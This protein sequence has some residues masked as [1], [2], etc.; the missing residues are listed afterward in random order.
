[1]KGSAFSEQRFRKSLRLGLQ[2]GKW[3]APFTKP[4]SPSAVIHQE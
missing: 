3:V 2:H 4:L 1:M